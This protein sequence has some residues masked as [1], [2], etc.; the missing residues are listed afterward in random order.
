MRQTLG[1][2]RIRIVFCI[3][4]FRVG[5]TELNAVRTAESLDSTRF[6]LAVVHLQATGPL[7]ARYEA[8]GIKMYHMPITNLY[9]PVTAIQGA[10]FGRLLRR[11][12]VD[13]V[14]T[15]DLYTNI[16]AAPWARL[17]GK[18]RVISSRRWW[19]DAPRAGLSTVNRW[20]YKF[21][22]RVLA[23]SPGVAQLLRSERVPAQKIVEVPNF[24]EESAFHSQDEASRLAIRR[25][26]GV[27]DGA[28]VV[29]IVARLTPVKNHALLLQAAS[30]LDSRFSFV[31]IGGGP[32]RGVLEQQCQKLGISRRVHFIGEVLSEHN[33][34]QY[35]DISV[36]CSRSEGFPN[37]IIE[38]MAVARPVIATSV[39][40]VPDV[41]N[42]ETG[43]LIDD[44]SPDQLA[45]ALRLLESD[46]ALRS[47]LGQSGQQ[48]VRS[49]FHQKIVMEKLS[50]LYSDVAGTMGLRHSQVL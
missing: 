41:V 40:G 8:L 39:G 42:Y 29:G 24:L 25:R 9:S 22:D 2:T 47:T 27:A 11:V 35:F 19:F 31:L 30:L 20:S 3:D 46:A 36:L 28:F 44:N 10:R 18:C 50:A 6:D 49:N 38:A 13:I 33:L 37:S 15:H 45:A 5:G 32:S 12:N 48:S 1:R 14:H 7:R 17:L 21:A 23:N 43:V 4:S 26:W 34:H 16:F